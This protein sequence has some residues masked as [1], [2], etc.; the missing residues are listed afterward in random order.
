MGQA[1][2]T[3]VR[4]IVSDAREMFGRGKFE[5]LGRARTGLQEYVSSLRAE[6]R[7]MDAHLSKEA[8][9]MTEGLVEMRAELERL[10]AKNVESRRRAAPAPAP[11]R[12]RKQGNIGEVAK[13]LGGRVHTAT[14]NKDTSK[15]T[16]PFL[17]SL[18]SGDFFAL[19]ERA[20]TF[21]RGAFVVQ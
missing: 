4:E 7:L 21:C 14:R 17:R 1:N 11:L 20:K 13:S 16:R 8:L 2:R 10:R 18:H 19:T 9:K 5:E 12:G 15:M 6:N 3:L